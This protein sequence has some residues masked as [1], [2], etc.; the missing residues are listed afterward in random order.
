[1]FRRAG[2]KVVTEVQRRSLTLDA[3]AKGVM[4]HAPPSVAKLAERVDVLDKA[5]GKETEV[6]SAG[7]VTGYHPAKDRVTVPS[8]GAARTPEEKRAVV[9]DLAHELRHVVNRLDPNVDVPSLEDDEAS[10]FTAQRKAE[11]E[12]S[13]P[14]SFPDSPRDRA[15]RHTNVKAK[16]VSSPDRETSCALM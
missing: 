16:R 4:E 1:M 10:A 11:D 3:A 7:T 14:H 12:L 6:Q 5:R 8:A 13:L 2:A 9:P 15:K